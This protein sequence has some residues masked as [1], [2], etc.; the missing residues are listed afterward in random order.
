M[1]TDPLTAWLDWLH[2]RMALA[3][4]DKP[5]RL[6]DALEQ[7]IGLFRTASYQWLKGTTVPESKHLPTLAAIFELGAHDQLEM[8]R[9]H[10]AASGA[11]RRESS[12]ATDA[13]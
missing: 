2:R 11:P 3:G 5:A 8:Y 10:A 4:M 12:S 6:A 13:A 9:L 7:R 1:T